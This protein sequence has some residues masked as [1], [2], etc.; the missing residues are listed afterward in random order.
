MRG[1]R[2][3]ISE[4]R[5]RKSRTKR[6]KKIIFSGVSFFLLFVSC[7]CC[8]TFPSFGNDLFHEIT[9]QE[10]DTLWGIAGTYLKDPNRWPE[11]LKSN[12]LSL[13][14]VSVILPGMRLKLPLNLVKEQFRGASLVNFINEVRYK[15]KNQ[16]I[17]SIVSPG[18]DFYSEDELKTMRESKAQVEFLS[19]DLLKLYPETSVIFKPNLKNREITLV[20]GSLLVTGTKVI[21]PTAKVSPQ[22]QDTLYKTFVRFDEATAVQVGKG[23]AEVLG[24]DTGAKVVVSAGYANITHPK[25][26]PSSPIL[27]PD[28]PEL[29]IVESKPEDKE[30]EKMEIPDGKWNAYRIQ[31]THDPKFSRIERDEKN[32]MKPD[33]LPWDE[34]NFNLPDGQYYRRVSYFDSSGQ[35]SRFY[36]LPPLT[37]YTHNPDLVLTLPEDG[38][39]TR[40]RFVYVEG[41]TKPGTIVTV[42]GFP[43]E[44]KPDGKFSW[45]VVLS[46]E[47]IMKIR[48]V[49]K[50][51]R[52]NRTILE[53]TVYKIGK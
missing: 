36:P 34:K 33:V 29:Q 11:I 22:T 3:K 46:K 32:E 48:V 2:S 30:R 24:L 15:R 16:T 38:F 43:V 6:E 44:V 53:R 10:G 40:D 51:L 1:V 49:A 47:G 12:H 20:R 41:N 50:D 23:S 27:V 37:I 17:W 9:V 21:T 19:H 4:D 7:F 13:S 28:I 31:L 52:N 45:S 14:D 5:N 25:Q 42:N 18:M 26:D 35:E 8:L 39:R